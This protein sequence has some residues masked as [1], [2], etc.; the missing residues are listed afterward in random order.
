MHLLPRTADRL[1][2]LAFVT[3]LALTSASCTEEVVVAYE[4]SATLMV[5]ERVMPEYGAPGDIIAIMGRNFGDTTQLSVRIGPKLA[6]IQRILPDRVYVRVPEGA[7]DFLVI[8]RIGRSSAASSTQEFTV[9]PSPHNYNRWSI[10]FENMMGTVY[11][12]RLDET[13]DTSSAV[14]SEKVWFN[15]ARARTWIIEHNGCPDTY[16]RGDTVRI[17]TQE[18]RLSSGP[19]TGQTSNATERYE[20]VAVVDTVRRMLTRVTQTMTELAFDDNPPRESS[21]HRY[22]REITLRDLPYTIAGNELVAIVEGPAIATHIEH[23]RKVSTS[24]IEGAD[25][26]YR[27]RD[28]VVSLAPAGDSRIV[29][30]LIRHND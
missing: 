18:R 19:G 27:T 8:S 25:G 28:E 9:I 5:V 20:L 13:G 3:L 21:V 15:L 23:F 2:P 12:H 29:V 6:K 16:G 26:W 30:K 1:R 7:E 24:D 17:C 14:G 11:S 4:E 10:D 22:S